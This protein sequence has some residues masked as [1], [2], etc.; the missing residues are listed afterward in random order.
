MRR[1]RRRTGNQHLT[2]R[3]R[4]K[5]IVELW[6]LKIRLDLNGHREFLDSMRG[7]TDDSLAYFLGLDKFVDEYEDKDKKEIFQMMR[8]R[9]EVL[10]SRKSLKFPKTLMQNVK[11]VTKLITLNPS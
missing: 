2:I 9:L 10:E 4:S 8:D 11:K 1:R 7:V 3:N 6:I 5:E